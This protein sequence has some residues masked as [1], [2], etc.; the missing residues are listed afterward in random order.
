M[1][2]WVNLPAN[3][4]ITHLQGGRLNAPAAARNAAAIVQMMGPVAPAKGY[5]LEIA[6]GTGQHI[7]QLAAALP[8]IIWQPSDVDPARLD[9]IAAWLAQTPLPNLRPACRLDAT[10]AGWA[11]T[12]GAQD[13][14]LLVNLLHLI[15]AAEA[16][17]LI[18]EMAT[19]LAPGGIAI[20][21]E[22]FMRSGVLTNAADVTFH[23]HLTET[24]PELGYKKDSF[25]LGLLST[26]GLSPLPPVVMPANNLTLMA[27]KS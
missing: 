11:K 14:I 1:S 4:S 7:V 21:Y 18:F 24:N 20:L 16:K 22:P 2:P 23:Q 15:T 10:A 9:S 12:H 17:T 6:S 25:V 13:L 3:A 8:N 26:A 19:A 27:Q 5:V